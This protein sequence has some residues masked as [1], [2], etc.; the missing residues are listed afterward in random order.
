[1]ATDLP[2]VCSRY[3][4]TAAPALTPHVSPYRRPRPDTPPPSAFEPDAARY[5]L[6][7][8]LVPSVLG[9]VLSFGLNYVP[10]VEA[11]EASHAATQRK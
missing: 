2:H 11:T 3:R 9:V 4:R 5:L 6:M 1:M 7:L 8:A 10:F